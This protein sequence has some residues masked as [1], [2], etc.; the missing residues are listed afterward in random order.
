M[1]RDT[2][3]SLFG[4]EHFCARDSRDPELSTF[5]EQGAGGVQ[6]RGLVIAHVRKAGYAHYCGLLVST[7][8]CSRD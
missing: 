1:T 5:D 3:T 2:T 7:S 6:L 4:T 8:A